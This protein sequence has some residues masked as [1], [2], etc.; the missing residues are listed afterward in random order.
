MKTRLNSQGEVLSGSV[1]FNTIIVVYFS[2]KSCKFRNFETFKRPNK[3][4]KNHKLQRPGLQLYNAS[5]FN[6][7]LY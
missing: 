4:T 5:I 2:M 6:M 3:R 1:N 7:T